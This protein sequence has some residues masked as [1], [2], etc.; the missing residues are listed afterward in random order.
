MGLEN[1][2]NILG[3]KS[4]IRQLLGYVMEDCW[5]IVFCKTCYKLTII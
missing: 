3:R 2:K 4:S 5:C 1:V